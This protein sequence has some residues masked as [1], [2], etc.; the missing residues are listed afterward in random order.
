MNIGGPI[1]SWIGPREI[2]HPKQVKGPRGATKNL[3]SKLWSGENSLPE[4]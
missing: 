3:P 1:E 4:F 2:H